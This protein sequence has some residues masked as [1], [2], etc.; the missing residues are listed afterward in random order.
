MIVRCQK[1]AYEHGRVEVSV[2]GARLLAR[3]PQVSAAAA[4]AAAARMTLSA[5]GAAIACLRERA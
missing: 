5:L 3:R 4:A 2:E 1:E